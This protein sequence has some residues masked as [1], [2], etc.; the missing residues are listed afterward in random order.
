VKNLILGSIALGIS[1]SLHGQGLIEFGNRLSVGTSHIY[2]PLTNNPYL[3]QHGNGSADSPRG[4]V[5]WSAFQGIGLNGLSGQFGGS[6]TLAQILSANGANQP[7]STLLPQTPTTTFR[8]GALGQ[9]FL[10]PIEFT[11]NNVPSDAPAATFAVAAWDDSSGLYSTWTL[12]SVAWEDG[13]IAAGET[14]PFTLT[15]IGCGLTTPP[16]T[17][18]PSFNLY[19]IA[20]IPEP[21][22][23]ALAGVAGYALF[24]RLCRKRQH[25][26]PLF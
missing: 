25:Q 9:G 4:N 22:T 5:N 8:T 18:F 1:I 6:T 2:A 14:A 21:S 3:S 15:E 12:A 17:V 26:R 16:Y 10:L 13:L 20:V 11:L 23:L 24:F 19:Y 7:A